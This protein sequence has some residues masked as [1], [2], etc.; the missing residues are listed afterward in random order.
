MFDV[1]GFQEIIL[2]AVV[3]LFVLGPKR[4]PEA[5]RTVG[6][7]IGKAKRTISRLQR[8]LSEE[9]RLDEIRNRAQANSDAIKERMQQLKE[10]TDLMEKPV[11]SKEIND[12]TSDSNSEFDT[13]KTKTL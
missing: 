10:E 6:S 4:M 1:F 8:E 9:L 13:S 12:S 5:L 2:I 7:W 3:G 11:V